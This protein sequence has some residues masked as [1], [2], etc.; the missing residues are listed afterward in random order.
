MKTKK[1]NQ[2][3][4]NKS[5]YNFST[6]TAKT[7]ITFLLLWGILRGES[8]ESAGGLWSETQTDDACLVQTSPLSDEAVQRCSIR[9][10]CDWLSAARRSQPIPAVA[11]RLAQFKRN[12]SEVETGEESVHFPA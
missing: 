11:A 8:L 9:S 12:V 10:P 5:H 1:Q 2:L 7:Q 4:I 3:H 6:L